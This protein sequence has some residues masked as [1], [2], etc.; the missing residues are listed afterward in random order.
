[1][2]PNAMPMDPNYGMLGYGNN[3]YG[4]S[5]PQ[6]MANEPLSDF[7]GQYQQVP[8]M[9]RSDI[10]AAPEEEQAS[11]EGA[12]EEDQPEEIEPVTLP[13]ETEIGNR[14]EKQDETQVKY[15]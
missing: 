11:E 10:M 7:Y 13:A 15:S 5:Y 1:M 9:A 14:T 2:I 12:A 4:Y 6:P 8:N 3:G